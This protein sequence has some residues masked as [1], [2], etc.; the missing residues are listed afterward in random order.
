[1]R[2]GSG[3]QRIGRRL[4]RLLEEERLISVCNRGGSR[5]RF[6]MALRFGNRKMGH[7]KCYLGNGI[8][9]MEMAYLSRWCFCLALLRW[10]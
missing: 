5:G 10:S 8:I 1:M 3:S 2:L 4:I 6:G 9:R 7:L